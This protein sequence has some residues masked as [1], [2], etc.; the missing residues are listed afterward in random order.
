MS[1]LMIGI[2]WAQHHYIF[3]LFQKT[4]HLLNLLNLFFLLALTK[5]RI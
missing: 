2:Y 5:L 3:K 1:T 4:N